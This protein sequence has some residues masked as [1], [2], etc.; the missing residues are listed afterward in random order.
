MQN[1][2]NGARQNINHGSDQTNHIYSTN[3]NPAWERLLSAIAG[4]GASHKAEHQFERGQ[5]LPGTRVAAIKAIHNWRSGKQR[6]HPIFRLSGAAGVG[7]SA[8][9]MTVARDCEKEGLLASSFFFFR[10]DSKRNNPSA[11]IPTIAH[12]LASTTP[13]IR[14]HI[15][16]ALSK[17]PGILDAALEHQF[18]CLILEPVLSW[19]RQNLLGF[20][21]LP[22]IVVLDGLDECGDE[23]G[24]ARILSIIQSAYHHAPGFP[25][26]FLICSRPEAWIREAFADEHL[27]ELSRSIVL[28]N[29]LAAQREDLAHHFRETATRRRAHRQ[30][31]DGPAQESQTN[32]NQYGDNFDRSTV[33]RVSRDTHNVGGSIVEGSIVENSYNIENR[34]SVLPVIFPY[35]PTSESIGTTEPHRILSL[36]ASS[37]S[38]LAPELSSVCITVTLSMLFQYYGLPLLSRLYSR[39]AAYLPP[40]P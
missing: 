15:E 3:A 22:S 30:H 18:C 9:A 25:L 33:H 38:S 6:E 14:N 2:N 10:S 40:A 20:P 19:S 13:F 28:D 1:I 32:Q 27:S 39:V 8:I 36:L 12:D 11:L 4:V 23:E 21:V 5:C 24:Q 26:R 37:L 7:K 31:P 17:D 16:Q 35:S 34:L 29:S